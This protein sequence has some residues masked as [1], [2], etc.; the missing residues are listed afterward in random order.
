MGS[1]YYIHS[2]LSPIPKL[3]LSINL[4]SDYSRFM[5][6]LQFLIAECNSPVIDSLLATQFLFLAEQNR[7]LLFFPYWDVAHA[8]WV[9]TGWIS[10]YYTEYSRSYSHYECGALLLFNPLC[11]FFLKMGDA[12]PITDRT[13][14]SSNQTLIESSSKNFSIRWHWFSDRLG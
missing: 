11:S 8:W 7:L 10:V 5:R 1:R 6:L 14:S 4:P 12:V 13:M 9:Q 3:Q 2:N